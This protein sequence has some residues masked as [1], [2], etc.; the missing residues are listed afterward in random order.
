ML[1]TCKGSDLERDFCCYVCEE[2]DIQT[3]AT[4]FCEKCSRC[5]CESCSDQHSRMFKKHNSIGREEQWRWQI[6]IKEECLEPIFHCQEHS[7]ETFKLL[8]LDHDQLLCEKCNL[9]NHRNCQINL[10]PIE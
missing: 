5:F 1:S 2:N 9:S 10:S 7:N 8:F 6:E 3:E 4:S